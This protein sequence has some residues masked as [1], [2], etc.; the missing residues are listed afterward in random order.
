MTAIE[1]SSTAFGDHQMIPRH[2]SG[3]RDDVSPP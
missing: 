2:Y 3:E 1:L